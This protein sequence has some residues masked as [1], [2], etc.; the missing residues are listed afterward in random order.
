MVDQLLQ[1]PAQVKA[2]TLTWDQGSEMAR[3]VD[4][5]IAA[6]V[7]IFFC[8]PAS[9]WQRPTNE[10]HNGLLRQYFAKGTDL[11]IHSADHLAEV[12]AELNDRPRKCLSYRTPAEVFY[13]QL[14]SPHTYV[15][16]T[17]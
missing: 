16:S 2:H 3:H 10:N 5:A 15:A 12:A 6:D 17:P 14:Q 4:I 13:E 8:D 7:K 11:S 1:L 9:P